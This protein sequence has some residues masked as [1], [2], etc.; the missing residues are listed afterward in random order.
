MSLVKNYPDITAQ[1]ANFL[2]KHK[3]NTWG[4]ALGLIHQWESEGKFDLIKSFAG[5]DES[6]S[7]FMTELLWYISTYGPTVDIEYL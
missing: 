2:K 3:P 7:Q 5:D 4:E 1:L 6:R